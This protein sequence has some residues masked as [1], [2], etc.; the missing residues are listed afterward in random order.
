M[1]RLL[2]MSIAVYREGY[3]SLFEVRTLRMMHIK[4]SRSYLRSMVYG[5]WSIVLASSTGLD[6]TF[7]GIFPERPFAVVERDSSSSGRRPAQRITVQSKGLLLHVD[8]LN[9]LPHTCPA[10]DEKTSK[11]EPDDSIEL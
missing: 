5:L 8:Q 7:A 2:G 1:A 3:A 4:Q 9:V 10:Q 6:L 11:T